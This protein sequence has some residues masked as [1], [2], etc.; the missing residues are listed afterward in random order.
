[1]YS[2]NC[3]FSLN[4]RYL[5]SDKVDLSLQEAISLIKQ[6][7]RYR[8]P[9]AVDF[10]AEIIVKKE[11]KIENACTLIDLA[12]LYNI[13]DLREATCQIIDQNAEI[14]LNSE[15]FL[16]VSVDCLTYI[17]KGDTF[18][19]EERLIFERAEE[20]SR[21]TCLKKGNENPD[22]QTLRQTLGKAFYHLRVPSLKLPDFMLC[23]GKKSYYSFEEYENIIATMAGKKVDD[24]CHSAKT[25]TVLYETVV[26]GTNN[27][28]IEISSPTISCTYNVS[29]TQRTILKGFLITPFN[30]REHYGLHV[31]VNDLL[32]C[33]QCKIDIPCLSYKTICTVGSGRINLDPPIMIGK[34]LD[35]S[36]EVDLSWL[37]NY[38]KN[39]YLYGGGF[40]T[41]AKSGITVNALLSEMKTKCNFGSITFISGEGIVSEFYFENISCR[42]P[43]PETC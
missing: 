39:M 23:V 28:I 6:A 24:L 2:I 38:G 14:I 30:F 40:S 10:C 1:M 5:Y 20:W 43:Y 9:S 13:S 37:F 8:V 7:H 22:D 33:I 15:T 18:K 25:R 17:F 34:Q 42:E 19:T 36:L 31:P 26:F 3:F 4:F 12:L 35:I 41:N 27:N 21:R 32:K 16:E 11:L 29:L